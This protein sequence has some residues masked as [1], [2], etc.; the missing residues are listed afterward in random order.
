MLPTDFDFFF[1]KIVVLIIL[2]KHTMFHQIWFNSFWDI[3]VQMWF[4]GTPLWTAAILK[5]RPFWIKVHRHHWEGLMSKILERLCNIAKIF[6]K[7]NRF[8]G[9]NRVNASY[10]YLIY[11]FMKLLYFLLYFDYNTINWIISP[12]VIMHIHEFSCTLFICC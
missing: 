1:H 2:F 10:F 11:I 6:H 7:L 9:C 5:W 8:T 3:S 4:R 12:W